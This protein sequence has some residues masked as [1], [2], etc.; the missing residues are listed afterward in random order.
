MIDGQHEDETRDPTQEAE[1]G[2]ASWLDSHPTGYLSLRRGDIVD[3][4]VVHVD[5]EEVLV[6]IGA[7]SE[8]IVPA[9][10]VGAPGDDPTRV[11]KVGDQVVA[12]VLQPEDPEGHV[13][14]SLTKA[15]AE[16]GWRVLQKIF[17]EGETIEAEVIDHNKG[18]LIV[19]V[20]GVRGFVPLSQIVDLKRGSAPDEAIESRLATMHGRRLLLKV[21]EMNRR[22]NRLILSERAAV[23][24]RRQREKDR[25]LE[26]LQE[27]DIR[28]GRVTS[29]CDFGAFV[30]LGGADGLIH[31]SEL[32]WG[33]VTHPSQVLK[34]GDEVEV[35]VVGID[36][37]KKKIALSLK[38]LQA[39]PWTRVAERYH[40]GQVVKGRITKLAPF[41]AFAEIDEGVEGLIHIS[42]LSEE[43]VT[44]PKSV[45]K[46]GD[47][48]LLRIIR[49]DAQRHRLGLSLRQAQEEEQESYPAVYTT[50]GP[51]GA[52][53]GEVAGLRHLPGRAETASEA[54]ATEGAERPPTAGAS[55]AEHDAGP[56]PSHRASVQA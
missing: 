51:T 2:L 23:Q 22:R 11:L 54:G 55:A 16:R 41:G 52:T 3:G 24:E 38:R 17:E 40:I 47:E 6:D 7:K 48:V 37:E 25:L 32:S 45:L 13:I 49:I 4:V 27:G 36:R 56:N 46:E 21:I 9:R 5:R 8:A 42:E 15:Q 10:E 31:V 20:H 26:E 30:D 1:Q 18:G 44:H 35:Y 29:L 43:R 28:T 14:L 34:V 50:Q 53:L 33:Q 19:N 39:E 12:Y